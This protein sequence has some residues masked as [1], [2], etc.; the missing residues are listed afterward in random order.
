MPVGD[1]LLPIVSIGR[2]IDAQWLRALRDA[3]RTRPSDSISPRYSHPWITDARYKPMLPGLNASGLT[4]ER[5]VYSNKGGGAYGFVIE[6]AFIQLKPD[7]HRATADR[8]CCCE[9]LC[10]CE[11]HSE[12]A[13]EYHSL[14][15]LL[16][17]I[18]YAAGRSR[19][20]VVPSL[21]RSSRYGCGDAAAVAS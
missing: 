11:S 10:Q 2:L 15:N 20:R 3:T 9:H 4:S 16:R 1:P 13:Y 7:G 8:P 5:I 12:R 6:N 17:A 14:A 18:G 19:S 21:N